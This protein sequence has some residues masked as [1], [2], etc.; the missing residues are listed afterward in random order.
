MPTHPSHSR[1][2]MYACGQGNSLR[3]HWAAKGKSSASMM[4]GCE[5]RG[6]TAAQCRERQGSATMILMV[7][8]LLMMVDRLLGE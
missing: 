5:S 1:S 6:L 8:I 7:R 4:A 2:D 3:A